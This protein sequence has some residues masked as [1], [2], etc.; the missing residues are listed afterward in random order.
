MHRLIG[1]KAGSAFRRI[2]GICVQ[3]VRVKMIT[4]RTF[5]FLDSEDEFQGAFVGLL[6]RT[7]VLKC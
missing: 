2:T 7:S 6:E 3:F 1:L 4:I 5:N